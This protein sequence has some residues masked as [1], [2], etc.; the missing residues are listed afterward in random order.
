[1][2]CDF[3]IGGFGIKKAEAIMMF[4]I[5]QNIFCSGRSD[6]FCISF[7]IKL[8]RIKRFL[9]ILIDIAQFIRE[10]KDVITKIPANAADSVDVL[11]MDDEELNDDNS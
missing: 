4:G 2:G 7:R 6:D 5:N 10:N 8:Q 3:I 1:M 9:Q 11:L